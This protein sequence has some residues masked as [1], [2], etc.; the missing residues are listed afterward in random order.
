M[1][2]YYVL[3][4]GNFDLP[5]SPNP[6]AMEQGHEVEGEGSDMP[7]SSE[8]E[9]R[10]FTVNTNDKSGRGQRTDGQAE[11]GED[12][13]RGFYASLPSNHGNNTQSYENVDIRQR[14]KTEG[15]KVNPTSSTHNNDVGGGSVLKLHPHMVMVDQGDDGNYGN[16]PPASGTSRSSTYENITPPVGVANDTAS[17]GRF[18]YENVEALLHKS[19]STSSTVNS[20]PSTTTS[21]ERSE[22][23]RSARQRKEAYEV[24]PLK[25]RK[26]ST[27]HHDDHHSDLPSSPNPGMFN[28]FADSPWSCSYN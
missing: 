22:V 15:S 8:G 1:G 3:E 4:V 18:R 12:D 16:I 19:P 20:T 21:A 27:N 17:G 25:N 9:C 10:Y 2:A 23:K 6:D 24:V 26:S 28:Y 7:L 11:D 13:G 5:Q 14:L